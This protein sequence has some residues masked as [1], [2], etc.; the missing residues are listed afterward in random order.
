MFNVSNTK[1]KKL[2]NSL[3]NYSMD[4]KCEM[5]LDFGIGFQITSP[6][7]NIVY[8]SNGKNLMFLCKFYCVL[9]R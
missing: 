2:V 7:S 3:R 9:T 5:G 1:Y 8:E 4:E 6:Y